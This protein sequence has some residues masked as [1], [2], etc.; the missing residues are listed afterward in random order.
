MSLNSS[1]VYYECDIGELTC[2]QQIEHVAMQISLW[3]LDT[4]VKHPDVIEGQLAVVA[5]KDV[6]LALDNVGCVATAR[7][8]AIV[9]SLHLLPHVLV[10]VE[11]VHIVHPVGPI[12][13]AKVINF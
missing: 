2:L 6:E 11:H 10:N 1:F 5:T 12:V 4:D 9:T 3:H 13:P 7:S 8:W